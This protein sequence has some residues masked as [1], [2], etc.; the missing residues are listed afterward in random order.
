MVEKEDGEGG[1]GMSG[2]G[3]GMLLILAC[4]INFK[5]SFETFIGSLNGISFG[6]HDGF[7]FGRKP[8][9]SSGILPHIGGA[10]CVVVSR[11]LAD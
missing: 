4:W 7:S 6:H 11:N 8:F 9:P 2:W 1:G 3:A 5:S 10:V